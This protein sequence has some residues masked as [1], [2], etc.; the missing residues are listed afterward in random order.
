MLR[1]RFS[2]L[3]VTEE[4]RCRLDAFSPDCK[5]MKAQEKHEQAGGSEGK[6]HALSGYRQSLA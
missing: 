1:T 4:Q 3:T 5:N 6:S 2:G